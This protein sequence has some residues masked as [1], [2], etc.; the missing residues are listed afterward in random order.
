[1]ET[2]REHLTE[3]KADLD[4]LPKKFEE[5]SKTLEYINSKGAVVYPLNSDTTGYDSPEFSRLKRP[6]NFEEERKGNIVSLGKLMVGCFVSNETGFKDFSNVDSEWFKNNENGI[7]DC[8]HVKPLFENDVNSERSLSEEIAYYHVYL[9]RK[10]QAEKLK[11]ASQNKGVAKALINPHFKGMTD[12]ETLNAAA[13]M[14]T[15]LSPLIIGISIAILAVITI[16]V[17][18]IN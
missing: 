16:M 17:F 11:G 18:L 14:H 9:K 10:R 13:K 1:M 6:M 8:F 15:S 2:I 5:L 12:D 4:E 7:F 3:E